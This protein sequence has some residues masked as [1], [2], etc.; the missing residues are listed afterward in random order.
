MILFDGYVTF[1]LETN[2]EIQ[3]PLFGEVAAPVQQ[4]VMKKC[5]R[6]EEKNNV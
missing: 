1:A 2:L 6:T 3:W 5:N 4:D